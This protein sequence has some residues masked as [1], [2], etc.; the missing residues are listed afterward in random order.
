[1][2]VKLNIQQENV[3][4]NNDDFI[5]FEDWERLN[6]PILSDWSKLIF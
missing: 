3:K 2:N 4:N 6:R 5:R 1:M